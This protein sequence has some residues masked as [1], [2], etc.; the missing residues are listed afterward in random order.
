MR[1]W[2]TLVG[3]SGVQIVASVWSDGGSLASVLIA[4][5]V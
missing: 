1:D 2:L 4:G 3:G 5:N